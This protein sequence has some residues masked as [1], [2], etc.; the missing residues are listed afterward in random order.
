MDIIPAFHRRQAPCLSGERKAASSEK[1]K[2]L[3]KNSDRQGCLGSHTCG[4]CFV[5]KPFSRAAIPC[6]PFSWKG[7]TAELR[8]SEQS[9]E[10]W[11]QTQPLVS[12]SLPG[13]PVLQ[14]S[15]LAGGV[16]TSLLFI[17]GTSAPKKTNITHFC[18][19]YFPFLPSG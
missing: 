6:N 9:S 18:G 3:S 5:S 14:H 12:P 2:T 16:S 1:S 17:P 13:F 4:V 19:V 7:E 11:T 15:S 8:R 10:P